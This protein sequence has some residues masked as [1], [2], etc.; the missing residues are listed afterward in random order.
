MFLFSSAF[1]SLSASPLIREVMKVF[2]DHCLS[3]NF[4]HGFCN[5]LSCPCRSSHR[6]PSAEDL[7][8]FFSGSHED[9]VLKLLNLKTNFFSFGLVSCRSVPLNYMY[10]VSLYENINRS[11]N[12]SQKPGPATLS[13]GVTTW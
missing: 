8:I 3:F 6:D 11:T 4:V 1:W 5:S 2:R 9:V 12:I 13:G 10:N 7:V